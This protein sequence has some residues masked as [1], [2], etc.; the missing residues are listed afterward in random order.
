MKIVTRDDSEVC[1]LRSHRSD[2]FDVIDQPDMANSIPRIM[3]KG[4]SCLMALRSRV[5]RGSKCRLLVS[6]VLH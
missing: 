2:D 3:D 6:E 4:F 5:F 1:L